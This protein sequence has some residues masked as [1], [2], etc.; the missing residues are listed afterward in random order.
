MDESWSPARPWLAKADNDLASARVL[1]ATQ[2]PLRDAAI[3][4]CQQAGEKALK[5]AL[6]WSR[7]PLQKTHDLKALQKLVV[8]DYPELATLKDPAELLNPYV[9]EF[10]YPGD[11][12]MPPAEEMQKA[13]AAAEEIVLAIHKLIG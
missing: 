5:A 13:I 3:F 10:R 11:L 1:A 9:T 8:A 12:F 6:A 2:P 4:H 7:R